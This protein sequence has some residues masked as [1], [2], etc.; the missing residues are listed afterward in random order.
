MGAKAETAVPALVETLAD[1][2]LEMRVA[3][4]MALE[5][6]GPAAAGAVPALINALGDGESRVRQTA[7]KAL[8]NIGPAA[9]EAVPVITR[10]VKRGAWPEAE[11]A[12][13]QIQ[14]RPLETPTPE[15]R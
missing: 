10:A 4:A 15:T 7:V 14:G 2:D 5:N 1:P 11:E 9:R 8:G 13:R 6:M 12:L 3:A